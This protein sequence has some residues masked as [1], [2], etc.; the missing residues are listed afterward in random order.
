[1]FYEGS[2]AISLASIILH[3]FSKSSTT[4]KFLDHQKFIDWKFCFNAL[5][6]FNI[7]LPRYRTFRPRL[8]CCAHQAEMIR[9]GTIPLFRAGIGTP[10]N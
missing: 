5:R 3:H 10:W 4:S 8:G 9:R 7:P 6:A 1:V 2:V